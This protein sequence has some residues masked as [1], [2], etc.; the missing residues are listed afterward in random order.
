MEIGSTPE[1]VTNPIH[2]GFGVPQR[3]WN[4]LREKETPEYGPDN[5]STVYVP[6]SKGGVWTDHEVASTRRRV[7]Q[8]IHPH[9]GVQKKQGTWVGV[10]TSTEKVKRSKLVLTCSTMYDSE[11]HINHLS[12]RKT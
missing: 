1:P 12:C 10:G 11:V 8:M 5:L 2:N 9:W 6:G 7:L 3:D 4:Y